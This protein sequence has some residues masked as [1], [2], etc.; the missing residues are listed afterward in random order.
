MGHEGK[1]RQEIARIALMEELVCMGVVRELGLFC[2]FRGEGATKG[3]EGQEGIGHGQDRMATDAEVVGWGA[4]A[5]R[6]KWARR[7]GAGVRTGNER[8]RDMASLPCKSRR[9]Y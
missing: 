5:E 1:G 8:T 3:T 7:M 9:E 2:T 6:T 4:K